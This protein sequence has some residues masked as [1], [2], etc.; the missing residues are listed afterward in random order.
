MKFEF[1]LKNFQIP[2][3]A[4]QEQKKILLNSD[5]TIRKK[6]KEKY[7]FKNTSNDF[8]NFLNKMLPEVFQEYF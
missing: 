7:K 2:L 8:V 5:K 6:W 1:L 4:R 3:F